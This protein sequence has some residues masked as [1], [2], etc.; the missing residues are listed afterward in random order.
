[1]RES[2][3]RVKKDMVRR[4]KIEAKK[5]GRDS[6]GWMEKSSRKEGAVVRCPA[7]QKWR[8]ARPWAGL[9]KMR[10]LA[11]FSSSQSKPNNFTAEVVSKGSSWFDATAL[12]EY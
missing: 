5:E 1:M 4:S 11:Q 8:E 2:Y 6:S 10:W 7:Q 9:R 12:E 3:V